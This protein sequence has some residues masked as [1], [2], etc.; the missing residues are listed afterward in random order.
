MKLEGL[1][2]KKISL[3][4]TNLLAVDIKSKTNI[5]RFQLWDNSTYVDSKIITD[6]F[7]YIL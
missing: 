6:E 1:K 7:S 2:L 4:E 3:K 5:T